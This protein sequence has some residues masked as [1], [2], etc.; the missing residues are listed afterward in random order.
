MPAP[1]LGG[2][3]A[4]AALALVR[5]ASLA[6]PDTSEKIAWGSPT[7]RVEERLFVMFMDNHHGD[8]RLAIWCHAA[9]GAQEAFVADD[10]ESYFVPPYVGPSGWIGVRLDRGLSDSEVGARIRAAH[11]SAVEAGA[12]R[13]E[14]RRRR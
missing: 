7:F 13:R 10:S 14:K 8:G 1:R 3:A 11:E 12:A 5:R 6:L 9:P 4:Q 2:V